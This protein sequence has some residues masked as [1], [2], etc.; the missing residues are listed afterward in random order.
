MGTNNLGLYAWNGA[1]WS[2]LSSGLTVGWNNISVSSYLTG[3]STTFTI[4]F[5][6]SG[7]TAAN[8]WQ[9]D[10]ALL[11]PESNQ[12][13]F[14]SLT[15]PA[16]TVA[17]E[18]LQNGTMIWLGQNLQITTQAI[19][20]PPVSVKAI[21]VNETINGVNEQVP[22]QVED[23]ASAYTVPLG[24]TNN[25]TVFGNRQMIVFLVNPQV[26]GFTLWWNGSDQAVQTS[27]AYASNYFTSDNTP[28]NYLTNGQLGL[29]FNSP[30]TV[31][32][33]VLDSG[34]S[35]TTSFMQ[36]NGQSSVYGSG[37]D[38]VVYNGVVRDIVQQEAEWSGGITNCPNL[39]ADIVLTLPANATYFTYQLSLMFIN[40]TMPRTITSLCPLTL[41]SSIGTLQTE[42]GTAQGDPIVASGTQT[43]SSTGT[44]V[45]HW[46]QF[47]NGNTGAG[48]MFT[49]QNNQLLYA[50]DSMTPAT[51]R[52]AL[53]ASSSSQTISLLPVTLNSV[54]FQTPYVITW[55]GAV[56]TFD[57][58]VPQIYNGQGQPALWLLAEIP[59][60]IAITSG[61]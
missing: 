53:S 19:P 46:S 16:A 23:W 8:S 39:Y 4:K 56:V 57:S 12:Y 15:N 50:F 41:S 9:V 37:I 13:L 20:V 2:S 59:P 27:L 21:H 29:Q 60:N 11:R 30:F 55:C 52:G 49:D 36:I 1:S 18:L 24:L 10:A 54:S 5:G 22:F 33:K 28:N 3:N 17:V 40:S 58:T 38:Y 26:S 42:N 34:T 31:T 51:T 35:S 7:D 61:N 43:F 6:T 14:N 47:T 48:I 44:W 25:A 45:H 32:S